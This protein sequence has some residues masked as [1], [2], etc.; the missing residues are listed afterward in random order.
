MK[1]S[2]V[3]V[4]I[5][6]VFSMSQVF[7]LT[8][9]QANDTRMTVQNVDGTTPAD[10][11]TQITY[12]IKDQNLQLCWQGILDKDNTT[13]YEL[14]QSNLLPSH[15][16]DCMTSPQYDVTIS[17]TEASHHVGLQPAGSLCQGIHNHFGI[18]YIQ[19]QCIMQ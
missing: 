3:L 4:A 11:M 17:G 9:S 8:T 10:K 7:A 16:A 13:P 19:V 1:L 14:N 15:P 6:I 5:A 2:K 12:T 18:N